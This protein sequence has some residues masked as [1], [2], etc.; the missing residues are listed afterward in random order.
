MKEEQTLY[1]ITTSILEKI[2]PVVESE[3]PDVVLVHGIQQQ[4]LPLSCLL[5][6]ILIGHVEAGL[7]TYR[8]HFQRSLI[9]RPFPIV[10]TL[11]LLHRTKP[12]K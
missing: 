6:L 7:R 11:T 2:K 5:F 4:P 9:D 12:F 8:A 1:S 3:K 10:S